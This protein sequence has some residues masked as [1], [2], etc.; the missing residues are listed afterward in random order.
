MP[1]LNRQLFVFSLAA[2]LC[3]L[4]ACGTATP[5][6]RPKIR[7][8]DQDGLQAAL[9]EARGDVVVLNFWATWC[10]PCVEEL[11]HFAQLASLLG[12]ERVRV[13][14]V[15]FD[16]TEELESTVRPFIEERNHPFTHLLKAD[17]DGE[18]YEAFI[19]AVDPSWRGGVPATFVYDRH[20]EMRVAFHEPV[21]YSDLEAA[22]SPYM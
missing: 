21:M 9:I 11:P 1:R 19:N 5:P 16:Q 20:G 14:T 3:V 6:E 18:E 4:V 12:D 17:T 2:L 7:I 15:S 8:V 13:I 22:V 10:T